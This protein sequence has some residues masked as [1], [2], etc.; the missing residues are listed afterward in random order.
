NVTTT[1]FTFVFQG[2]SLTTFQAQ[3]PGPIRFNGNGTAYATVSGDIQAV[4][5]DPRDPS[6]NV[7]YVGSDNGGV[8]KTTDGG[9]NWTPLT[10]FLTDNGQPSGTP[11][12]API[13]ALAIDPNNPDIIYAGTGIADTKITS[14]PGF[15]ILKST[16]AGKTWTLI[17]ANVFAG[18]RIAKIAVSDANP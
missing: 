6:G 17:G 15:G 3:G 16:D 9:S 5:T 4:V 2:P 7:V 12:P 18:A 1:S 10:Q 8:W 11:I 14:H 13:G